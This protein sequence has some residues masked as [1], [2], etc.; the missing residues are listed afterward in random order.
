MLF[1][2]SGGIMPSIPQMPT[3]INIRYFFDRATVKNA[4]SSMEY[5][6]LTKAGMLVRF[7]AIKSIGKQG[8][9]K[10]QLKEM[11]ANPGMSLDTILR[12]QNLSKRKQAALIQRIREIKTRPPSSPGSPPN[13]HVPYKHMLG[14]RRNLYNAFDP[15]SRSVVVGPTAKGPDHGVPHLHEFGGGRTLRAWVWKPKYPRYTK[16]IVQWLP[17]SAKPGSGWLPTSGRRTVGYPARP[18]M[19][20]ALAKCMPKLAKL[21]EGQ[22]TAGSY[23]G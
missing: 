2:R 21:F 10:P 6:A 9:A 20:P 14:F 18:F 3:S 4:L 23:G 7:T 11:K 12:T 19:K 1:A 15:Q 16:P 5:K 17:A 22:F 13:T 8:M